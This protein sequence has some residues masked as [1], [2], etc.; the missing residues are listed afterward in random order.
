MALLEQGV[1]QVTTEQHFPATTAHQR[2]GGF[3]LN[4][5]RKERSRQARGRHGDRDRGVVIDY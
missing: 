4:L 5:F 2:N 3:S 1:M